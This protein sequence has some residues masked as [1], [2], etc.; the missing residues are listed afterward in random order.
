M[1]AAESMGAERD[2]LTAA[3]NSAVIIKSHGDILTLTGLQLQPLLLY[4]GQ[5]H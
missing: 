4:A 1:E 5:L 2:H 3:V